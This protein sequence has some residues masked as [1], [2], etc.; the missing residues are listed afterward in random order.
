MEAMG[1]HLKRLGLAAFAGGWLAILAAS[2]SPIWTMHLSGHLM[3][4]D[5]HVSLWLVIQE[6][7]LAPKSEAHA[8]R[9]N[10]VPDF[11]PPTVTVGQQSIFLASI[12]ILL[13]SL[14]GIWLV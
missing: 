14:G 3:D 11:P 5:V 8:L 10:G 9:A 13:G 1:F 6:T 7:V 4:D 12:L 2:F